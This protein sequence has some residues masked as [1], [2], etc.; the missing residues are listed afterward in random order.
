MTYEITV[1]VTQAQDAAVV[2]GHVDTTGIPEF[3]GGAFGEVM[4]VVD[5]SAV[6]G[7]PFARY[8]MVDDG[9]DIVAGFPVA[10]PVTP[11]GRVVA[12]TLPGGTKA[13][14]L[15]RGSYEGIAEAWTAMESWV[16]ENG[17]VVDA[18]PWESYLDGPDVA[19]PRTLITWPVRRAE[20]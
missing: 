4:A 14:L 17:Y 5:G 11:S 10:S 18:D 15:Y 12:T 8:V 3:L 16:A 2:A 7:P 9:F 13:M 6:A 20:A 19:E 1:S